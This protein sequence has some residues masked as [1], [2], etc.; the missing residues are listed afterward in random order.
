LFR[1]GPGGIPYFKVQQLGMSTKHLRRQDTPYLVLNAPE[2][3][4]GSVVFAK[5]GAAIRLNNLRILAEPGYMD[6]NVMALTPVGEFTA[7]YLFY[8]LT[9]F[10]LWSV[11]DITSIPQINN[12]HIKPLC[13]PLPSEDEQRAI[14]SALADVDDLIA[15][16]ERLVRK[17]EVIRQGMMQQLLTART[18]LPGFAGRWVSLRVASRSVIKA[19]IGWQGLTTSEY[20][21]TGVYRLVGGAEFVDG[22]VDWR[23]TPYVTK[24]RYDQDLEIQLQRGDVLL[25]KDGTIGKTAYAD[26]LPGPATLNSGVFVIRPIR[27]AYHSRFL[28]YMLRS[29]VFDEFLSRLAAG[30]TI[31][32]LYQRDL[33]GLVLQVPPTSEEQRLIAGSLVDADRDVDTLRVRLNKAKAIKQGMM[34]ELLT[35]RTRLPVAEAVAA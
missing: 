11:A 9:F 24:W 27:K 23:A 3:A 20:R 18:R 15:A 33:V 14:T 19:R 12:K 6:T 5:R 26:E 10:G 2:V 7:E 32:H 31:S 21:S 16:L 4:Q 25:T 35:G 17:K 34:Q 29:R 28:Y 13:L 1:F 22:D 8:A 30:S